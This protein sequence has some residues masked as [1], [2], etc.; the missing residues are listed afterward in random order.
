MNTT[1]LH[2]ETANE[3][4]ALLS[5]ELRAELSKHERF[6][7]VPKGTNL[8]Q[9]GV[10]PDELV[11]VNSGKVEI[12]LSCT[13]DSVSLDCAQIG[14][15]F[16]MCAVVSGEVPQADVTS[17]DNCNITLIPRDAFL[18]TVREHPQMYFAIAKVLS[19]DLVM[20]QR[21]LKAPLRRSLRRKTMA[22]SC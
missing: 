18:T 15:V 11:I 10:P 8:I 14:K 1:P 4:Y 19:S 20:A 12:T 16:G 6:M 2:S 3:L 17:Q 5:P 22:K 13:Q 21:F 7:S 9:H